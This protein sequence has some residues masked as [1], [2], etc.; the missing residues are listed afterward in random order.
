ME[1]TCLKE[2]CIFW[3][4]HNK[5]G[6]V[7]PFYRE[8]I[9]SCAEKNQPAVIEDCAPVRSL[10]MQMDDHNNTMGVKQLVGEI[11]NTVDVLKKETQNFMLSHGTDLKSLKRNTEQV[12]LNVSNKKLEYD[13]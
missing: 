10:F 8:T 11:R 4:Q 2:K 9:W 6:K 5:D 7:C 1:G 12:L 13:K 3:E